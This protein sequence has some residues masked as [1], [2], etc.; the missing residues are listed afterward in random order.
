MHPSYIDSHQPVVRRRGVTSRDPVL[1]SSIMGVY[2]K[3]DSDGV[4]WDDVGVNDAQ[5]LPSL[6]E[7]AWIR[8]R[9]TTETGGM[10]LQHCALDACYGVSRPGWGRDFGN[11]NYPDMSAEYAAAQHCAAARMGYSSDAAL[12]AL[13]QQRALEGVVN[14][15]LNIGRLVWGDPGEVGGR[16][17]LEGTWPRQGCSWE[18]RWSDTY[19]GDWVYWT[20]IWAL[21]GG[22]KYVASRSGKHPTRH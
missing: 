12:P 15:G 1:A 8:R 6:S 5:G 18:F 7:K 10:A 20:R 9:Q 16:K 22:L 13:L 2:Q 17:H 4:H 19:L 11:C 3:G 21:R 14:E